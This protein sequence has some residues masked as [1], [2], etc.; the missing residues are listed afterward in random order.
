MKPNPFRPQ[1]GDY[2]WVALSP[3]KIFAVQ[4]NA[5]EQDEQWIASGVAYPTKQDAREAM[6]IGKPLTSALEAV[7]EALDS[8]DL[9]EHPTLGIVLYAHDGT[10]SLEICRGRMQSIYLAKP[11]GGVS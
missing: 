4:Y 10:H 5:D 7:R 8:I 6:G 2:Y 11:K 1:E 9:L 3:H